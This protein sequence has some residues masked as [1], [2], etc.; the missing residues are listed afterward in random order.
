MRQNHPSDNGAQEQWEAVYH[1]EGEKLLGYLRK[2][3]G[4]E[5]ARDLFQESYILLLTALRKGN[6]IENAKAYLFQ[7]ARN[8]LIKRGKKKDQTVTDENLFYY[9]EDPRVNTTDTVLEKEFLEI[10][11][12]ARGTLAPLEQEIVELRWFL[13]M[14]QSEVASIVGKSERQIRRDIDR[15]IQKLRQVFNDAGWDNPL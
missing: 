4:E 7:I 3:V 6:R 15:I 11:E 8:L 9:I 1:S 2:Q 10:L 12:R 5:A 13:G 14:T